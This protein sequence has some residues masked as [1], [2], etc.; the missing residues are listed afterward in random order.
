MHSEPGCCIVSVGIG[1]LT[2]P[3]GVTDTNETLL[4]P[5]RWA[6]SRD[7]QAMVHE[8]VHPFN[9]G[10]GS[11]Y[12]MQPCPTKIFEFLRVLE[13]HFDDGVTATALINTTDPSLLL[14]NFIVKV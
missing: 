9:Q 7:T 2:S 1:K 12:V 14:K 13:H 11:A 8:V 3:N 5:K 10:R 6:R 4:F